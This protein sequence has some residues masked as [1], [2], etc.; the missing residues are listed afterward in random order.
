M[1]P[2]DENRAIAAANTQTTE[3]PRLSNANDEQARQ[4]PSHLLKPAAPPASPVLFPGQ[5]E[6]SN[7]EGSPAASDPLNDEQTERV[8][9]ERIQDEDHTNSS[10]DVTIDRRAVVPDNGD[11]LA[12]G[13]SLPTSE[14]GHSAGEASSSSLRDPTRDSTTTVKRKL[15]LFADGTGNAFAKQE[16]S[17]W[18]LYEALDHTEPDQIAHYIKGV[19]TADWAPLAAL[20]GATG[21]GVPSN[22]RKLY[23][24]LCWNWRSGDEIYIFGFSRGAFTA[25]TLAALISSQGLVP[26]AI[27]D[28]PMSHEE[29]ERNSMAAWREYR[30]STVPWNKTLP[31]IW[32]ARFVRDVLLYLYHAICGHH[33][34][35]DVRVAMNDRK[36][37][38]IEFLGLFDTVEAFGVP[39]EELRIAIDWAIW[40][41]S[42][43][44]HRLP[45]KVKHAC[46][47]LALDDER[48]TFHPLRIDQSQLPSDQ[49]VQEVWFAGVHS[50]IG[51]GYPDCTLSFVPLVW[52]IEQLRDKLR[53]QKGAV[54]HFR[55]YQSAI[56]PMHDSR[57]GAAVLYRYGPRPIFAGQINGGPPVVHFAVVERML[58]GFDDYAPV[59]LPANAWVFLPNGDTKALWEANAREALKAAYLAP[60]PY[61]LREEEAEA[62]VLMSAPDSEMSRLV[63]DTVWWRRVVYF[64][65][66]FMVG[67]IAL[68]PWIAR[69]MVGTSKDN[70]L[71]G[72][73]ALQIITTIDWLTG[74]VLGPLANLLR[75]VLPSYAAPWLDITLY[76]PVITACVLVI[77]WWLWRKNAQLRDTIQQRARLAWNGPHRK[78]RPSHNDW[79]VLLRRFVGLARSEG[80]VL[81]VDRPGPL[82]MLARWMR[83]HAGP[84]K[85]LFA[86]LV[87]PSIF[88]FIIF[89]AALLIG[90]TSVFTAR[91]ATGNICTPPGPEA[92]TP[93]LDIPI[94]ARSLFATRE[95]CWWSGLALEKGRK[96]RVWVEIE[97]PWFDRTIMSGT[98]GF[99]TY[100][101]PHYLALPTL[102]QFG[103]AWFQPVVRV[104]ARGMSDVPLEA[105]NVMPADELPR[106]MNPAIP[107]EDD[108]DKRKGR[109]PTQLDKTKEFEALPDDNSLKLAVSRLGPF[110]PVPKDPTARAIWEGQKLSGRLVAEFVAPDAGDLFFYVNDAVQIYPTLLPASLRPAKLD[111]VQGPYEQF[112][113]NNAGTARIVI[114]RLPSP[115]MPPDKPAAAKQ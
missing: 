21:I 2:Q 72:T 59:M 68:W 46:H 93:V 38:D 50:D 23:R 73:V 8:S 52:M 75:N 26:A 53:F 34:Y 16:S 27:D 63:R 67:V 15:V 20:D 56:G 25:R 12:T 31:T 79:H 94:E 100:F 106:R 39:I 11:T 44:N 103:A 14:D 105:V 70:G 47:A 97:D 40:P 5:L 66:L 91:T 6:A 43:R 51:G 84:V 85:W 13:D 32:I 114:Q 57:S 61:R 74:A 82:L 28:T 60:A 108:A 115:P 80:P 42:F 41:I 99:R 69:S 110:E 18:R 7:K 77:T 90:A 76:Y 37:V 96:Y 113:K 78:A 36:D 45:S 102:R 22:V 9:D 24:F 49:I 81:R 111:V 30:R 64:A 83:L 35:A 65:L 55:A 17:V 1:P 101:T 19:G 3:S 29:M 89:Y 104:G 98:N 112:Y 71:Q 48:T 87:L 10:N 33:S 95:F 86:K 109:Y 88:L 4:Q 107:A 58:R 92:G 54:E 62:F